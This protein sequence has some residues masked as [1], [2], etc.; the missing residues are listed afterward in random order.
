M[1]VDFQNA[2]LLV[3]IAGGIVELA[4]ALL[5]NPLK[6]NPRVLTGLCIVA[7]FAAVFALRYSVWAHEQVIGNH[8]LDEL[9]V[10]SLI[11]VSLALAFVEATAFTVLKGTSNAVKN[12]GENY[13]P[14]QVDWSRRDS[15][16]DVPAPVPPPANG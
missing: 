8:P 11:V 9:S 12:V 6:A 13:A 3:F 1:T 16:N 15:T 4:K 10:G 7:G 14:L 5:G 2:V